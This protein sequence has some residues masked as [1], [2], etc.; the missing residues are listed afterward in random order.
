VDVVKSRIMGD[1]VVRAP[2]PPR[3]ARRAEALTRPGSASAE[4]V[5]RHA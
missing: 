4:A 5:Q 3:I 1:K 2:P